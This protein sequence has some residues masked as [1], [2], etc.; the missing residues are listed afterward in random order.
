MCLARH[1]FRLKRQHT[2]QTAHGLA[3]LVICS[4]SESHAS[5]QPATA[6][7]ATCLHQSAAQ[8]WE[9]ALLRCRQLLLQA[10]S[11]E[12]PHRVFSLPPPLTAASQQQ[13]SLTPPISPPPFQSLLHPPPPTIYTCAFAFSLSGLLGL[14]PCSSSMCPPPAHSPPPSPALF[15]HIVTK[16]TIRPCQPSAPLHLP[17]L[18]R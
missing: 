15:F 13:P 3:L 18:L 5:G 16:P 14:P 9:H 2:R 11:S 7:T 12:L 17:L 4:K 10:T 8:W 6:Q 1:R